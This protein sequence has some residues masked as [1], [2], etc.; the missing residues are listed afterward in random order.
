M[1]L[2]VYSARASLLQPILEASD[3]ADLSLPVPIKALHQHPGMRI[4]GTFGRAHFRHLP[5]E[6]SPAHALGLSTKSPIP[7]ISDGEPACTKIEFEQTP[8][9]LLVAAIVGH[10][11]VHFVS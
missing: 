3:G 4:H 11:Q 7:Q 5:L 10:K 2:Q 6:C 1:L 8:I 9:G